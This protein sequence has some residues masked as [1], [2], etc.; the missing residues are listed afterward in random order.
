MGTAREACR[1]TD[2]ASIIKLVVDHE[3]MQITSTGGIIAV[4]KYHSADSKG[5]SILLPDIN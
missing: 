5:K 2:K 1:T 3:A 4:E